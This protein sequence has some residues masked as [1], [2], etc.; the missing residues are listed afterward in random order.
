[1]G[2]DLDVVGVPVVARDADTLVLAKPAG[3]AAETRGDHGLLARVRRAGW[4]EARVPHRLDRGTDGLQV[5][6]RDASAVERH[7]AALRADRWAK[8]YVAVVDQGDDPERLL[9]TH[10]RYLRRDGRTATVAHS[11]GQPAWQDHELVVPAP[12]RDPHWVVV[13]RLRTGRYHQ[14][15]AILADLGHPLLGD[16]H[17]RAVVAGRRPPRTAGESRPRL[18]HARL[19]GL[20]L[21]GD[22]VTVVLP[23]V[24]E[25]P[26]AWPRAV[27]DHLLRTD[28]A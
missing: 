24:L 11:G 26:D 8:R 28:L 23:S 5:V 27:A 7:N 12:G 1:M 21:D 6:A 17:Y 15:R 4:P 19:G 2:L 10:R 22:L 13:V 14:V 16:E 20:E 3:L 25:D 9:G 18:T